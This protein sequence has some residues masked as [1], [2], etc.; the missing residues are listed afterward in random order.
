MI[1]HPT[2]GIWQADQGLTCAI[3]SDRLDSAGHDNL[4]LDAMEMMRLG[5][6]MS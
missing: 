4:P 2:I 5:L 6:Q 1:S 3:A